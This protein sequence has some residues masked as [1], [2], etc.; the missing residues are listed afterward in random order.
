MSVR[1]RLNALLE[2]HQL[3]PYA[4]A[5]RSGGRISS[6]TIHR[7]ARQEGRVKLFDA[8]LL[9]A[10]C[11]VLGVEPSELLEREKRRRTSPHAAPSVPGR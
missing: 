7:L 3:T 5:K 2:E 4:L 8:D 11:D 6:S 10:L 9:D 1:L